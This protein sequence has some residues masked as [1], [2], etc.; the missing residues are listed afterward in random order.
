[1]NGHGGVPDEVIEACCG[2]KVAP[3]KEWLARPDANI[4]A[5]SGMSV[6]SAG[7]EVE[8]RFHGG[9]EFYEATV[10]AGELVGFL[11]TVVFS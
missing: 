1:L 10:K 11:I 9:D 5:A 2:N 8:A 4:N 6:L 3:I 7:T